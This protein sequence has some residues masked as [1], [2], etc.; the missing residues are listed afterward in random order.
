MTVHQHGGHQTSADDGQPTRFLIRHGQRRT[1]DYPLTDGGR[2]LPAALRFYH[3]HRMNQTARNN[4]FG[5]QGMFLTTDPQ[6]PGA[7]CRTG[8]TTCR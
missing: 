4:W 6:T 5:L 7:A 8:A 1:Y 2:T 3:D